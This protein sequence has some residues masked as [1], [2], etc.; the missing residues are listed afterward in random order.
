MIPRIF[1]FLWLYCASIG[2]VF[3]FLNAAER[4]SGGLLGSILV[5]GMAVAVYWA[6]EQTRW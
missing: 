2:G 3:A 4:M 6:W 1:L 5:I